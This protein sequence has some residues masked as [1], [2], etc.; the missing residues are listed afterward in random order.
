MASLV[1]VAFQV[2]INKVYWLTFLYPLQVAPQAMPWISLGVISAVSILAGWL[3]SRFCPEA[4]GSGIPQL[5]LAFWKDFGHTPGHIAIVKFIASSLSIGGG[6]SLGREGPSVQLGGTVASVLAGWFGVAKQQKRAASAAGAAAGLAA[7]FNAPLASVA[8]VLEEIL[9]DLNSRLLGPVLLASVIGAF[10]VHAFL[11]AQPA[12]DLPRIDEPT[13]R[14]YVIMPFCAVLATL[15][16]VIFQRSTL[17]LR[18]RSRKWRWLPPMWRPLLAG[19]LTWGLGMAVYARTG[20]L[21]VFALGYDDL[22][23]AL[24]KG[25]VWKVAALL[26]VAKLIATILCYGL[27]GS[28]GIF[29]PHL[30]FGGMCGV[31]VAGVCNHFVALNESDRILL[32]VGGMSACLGGVVQAPV[33]SVLI[34]FEMTHQFALVPGLMIAALVSQL[35]ARRFNH[36]NFYQEALIQDGHDMAHVVPPR[37][38]RSWQ[39]LPVSAIAHFEPVVLTDLENGSLADALEKTPYQRYPVAKDGKLHGILLRAEFEQ[40]KVESRPV[41]LHPAVT[42]RPSQTIR[43]CQMLLIES[44]SGLIVITDTDQGRPLAVVTLHDL[45]RAQTAI[46]DREG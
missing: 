19:W 34:I 41:S 29:S 26:L 5:K 2:A 44:V 15:A 4:A 1:A 11:G 25:L 7:A 46:S 20:R 24:S 13:W 8:F 17:S 28:G 12:F 9:E 14:A 45:L 38:L 10:V 39:N 27:G 40:A 18:A 23:V 42:A 33:T 32:A 16:G 22:S 3:L 6:Q 37:D 31:A 35:V 30:F 21:G 43:Q 36:E